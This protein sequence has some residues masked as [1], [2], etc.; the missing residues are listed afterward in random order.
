MSGYTTQEV[1][2]LLGMKP[3]QVRHYVRSEV[4]QPGRGEKGEYLFSF[5]D[6]VLLRT[7]K[8]LIDSQITPRRAL[9]VLRR[10]RQQTPGERPLSALR[11]VR[12]GESVL[13]CAENRYWNA[14]TGQ[15]PLPFAAPRP[16]VSVSTI[17]GNGIVVTHGDGEMSSDEWYNLGLD[18]EESE[19]E[20]APDAYQRAIEAD[21]TNVD[22]YVN[23]GRL[24]QLSGNLRSAK[25][26]YELVLRLAPEHHLA[27]YNLGTIFDELDELVKA[28]EYYR[29]AQ[30][31]PDAHFNLARIA[32]LS[33]DE[34]SAR[35]HMR[36]YRDLIEES[37][38]R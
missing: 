11:L 22:A 31:V 14:E 26:H 2:A 16:A 20:K 33:G 29:K 34:M 36:R 21:P 17:L 1:S 3:H 25:R 27:N 8:G 35:R 37:Q 15:V 10:L 13:V 19:I 30:G 28:A 5:R 12:D 9:K 32:E 4:V 23:A 38:D 18:L 7:A 6:V 24:H